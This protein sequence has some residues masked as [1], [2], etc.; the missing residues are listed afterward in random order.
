M[1]PRGEIRQ[2][3]SDVAH[4]VGRGTW[5]TYAARACVGFS[6]AKQTVRDMARAGELEV[7]GTQAVPG[8]CRPML[9]YAP[10]TKQM[11]AEGDP[12]AQIVRCWADF[13]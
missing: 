6:A 4:E 11:Q 12:L 8:V 2:A 9:V 7:V 1:R 10:A 13:R 3:L 5:R